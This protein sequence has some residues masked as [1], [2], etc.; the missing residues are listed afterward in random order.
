MID[1]LIDLLFTVLRPAQEFFNFWRRHHCRWFRPML[2]AQV[3]WAGR[4]LYRSTPPVTWD[5]GFSGL[6]WRTAPFNRLLRHVWEFGGPIPTQILTGLTTLKTKG[7]LRCAVVRTEAQKSGDPSVLSSI[8]IVG[9]G[10]CSFEFKPRSRVAVSVDT[11]N[12]LLC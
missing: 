8:P 5:L 2:G 3:L 12:N 9:H 7:R 4:D 1:W 10:C 11:K 6:I